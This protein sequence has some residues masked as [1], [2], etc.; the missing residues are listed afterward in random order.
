MGSGCVNGWL[1]GVI[2]TAT[3]KRQGLANLQSEPAPEQMKHRPNTP[4]TTEGLLNLTRTTLAG[5]VL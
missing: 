4:P 3:R 1:R 2:E 5:D